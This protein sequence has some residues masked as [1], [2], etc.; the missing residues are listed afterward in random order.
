MILKLSLDLPDDLAFVHTAR[1]LSRTLL[2]DIAVITPDIDDVETIM[3]EL[4]T[5]V[6]RHAHTDRRYSVV[7][8]YYQ[9]KVVITVTDTGTGFDPAHIRPV[10]TLRPDFGG[11]TRLGG[12]GM[13]ILDGLSDRLDITET[14]PHGTTVRAEKNLHYLS[15]D[16]AASA[17]ERDSRPGGAVA[18][19]SGLAIGSCSTSLMLRLTPESASQ[20]AALA[21]AA[22]LT[23]SD[24]ALRVLHTAPFTEVGV[25]VASHNKHG[26]ELAA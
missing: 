17:A 8:E 23:L 2:H 4:C 15:L 26:L 25:D 5:N 12:F 6:V 7:L 13:M 19:S 16:A 1:L 22:A 24:Y 14:D 9:P 10:G 18:A 20:L 11:K 3:S 21:Q